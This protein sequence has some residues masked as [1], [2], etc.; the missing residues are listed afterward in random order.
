[1][2]YEISND[3]CKKKQKSLSGMLFFNA[4]KK[5]LPLGERPLSFLYDKLSHFTGSA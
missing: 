5:G 2:Y 4:Q 1:M 3:E